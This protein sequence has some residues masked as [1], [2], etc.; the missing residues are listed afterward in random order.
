MPAVA[1]NASVLE[2][3]HPAG[4]AEAVKVIG[5]G[6]RQE[7]SL[8]PGQDS[9]GTGPA[10]LVVLAP[11]PEE[12]ATTGWLEDAVHEAGASLNRDGVLYVL[13]HRS[14]RRQMRGLL[15]ACGLIVD[16]VLL[17]H[18]NWREAGALIPLEPRPLAYAFS[19]LIRTN[20]VRRRIALALMRVP[21]ALALVAELLPYVGLVAR[22]RE[23]QPQSR[24]LTGLVDGE[25]RVS[26]VV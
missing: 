7:F 25:S 20:P 26:G 4:H 11:S 9:P 12:L 17:H 1:S 3:F 10:D 8:C 16:S 14:R 13:S 2:L 5:R 21:G 18:P 6:C 22:R 15:K 19:R 24:G 23:A